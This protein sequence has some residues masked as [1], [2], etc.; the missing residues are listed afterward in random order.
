LILT[1]HP[2]TS[3]F[4]TSQQLHIILVVC[5]HRRSFLK[6]IKIRNHGVRPFYFWREK[7]KNSF[8]SLVSSYSPNINTCLCRDIILRTIPWQRTHSHGFYP[9]DV[10]SVSVYGQF[11]DTRRATN[12]NRQPVWRQSSSCG[13]THVSAVVNDRKSFSKRD[14]IDATGI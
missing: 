13:T 2:L 4:G 11:S 6:K 14:V 9:G 7:K 12:P 1:F 8:R 10:D 3:K 5:A